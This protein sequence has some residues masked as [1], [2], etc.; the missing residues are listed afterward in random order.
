MT[1]VP[2]RAAVIVVFCFVGKKRDVKCSACPEEKA[3]KCGPGR[4]L[5]MPAAEGISCSFP[6]LFKNQQYA[7]PSALSCFG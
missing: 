4:Q 2:G 3:Q 5:E 1:V 6:E 7:S